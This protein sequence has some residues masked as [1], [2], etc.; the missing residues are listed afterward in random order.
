MSKPSKQIKSSNG[1]TKFAKIA[2]LPNEKRFL[3]RGACFLKGEKAE[4]TIIKG[5]VGEH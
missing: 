1:E 3:L 4:M 5:S 2:F